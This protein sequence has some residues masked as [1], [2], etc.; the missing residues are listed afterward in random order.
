MKISEKFQITGRTAIIT[1]GAG[2]LGKKHAEVITEFSG[3]PIF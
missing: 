2:L 1:G 3:N